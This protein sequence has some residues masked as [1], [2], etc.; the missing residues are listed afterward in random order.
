MEETQFAS[1]LRSTPQEIDQ[2]T[3]AILRSDTFTKVLNLFPEIVLILDKNRQTVYCNQELLRLLGLQSPETILGKRPGELFNC[4]NAFKERGGCGTSEFCRECGAVNAILIAQTGKPESRE[5]RITIGSPSR[6]NALDL[7]VWAAPVELEKMKFTF[8][9]IRDIH[10]EKRRAALEQVFFHDILN[11]TFIL[12][13]YTQNVRDGVIPADTHSVESIF[14][15]SKRLSD[16]ILD[17]RNLLAA[18]KGTYVADIQPVGICSMLRELIELYGQSSLAK[19]V[20]LRLECQD[21]DAK[22]TTDPHLLWRTLGNLLKNALEATPEQG[23]VTIGFKEEN[24]QRIFFVNNPAVMTDETRHQIFQRSFSTKG[25]GRGLGTY[26]V[27]LFA[28]Q[29]LQGKV[30]FESVEGPGTTFFVSL[31]AK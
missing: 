26:S 31:P 24:G 2:A 19:N 13:A 10:D 16:A 9:V 27:K 8:F 28:E 22:I 17:Q 11:D 1:P 12:K 20:L 4:I 21:P 3:Q 5:C 18:E 23:T 7:K 14:R 15:F 25:Q 29:Y 6:T 30:W